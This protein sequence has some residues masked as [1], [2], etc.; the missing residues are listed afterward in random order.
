MSEF[1]N[2]IGIPWE[3]G[4][5]GPDSFDC[6]SFASR[7]LAEQFGRILPQVAVPVLADDGQHYIMPDGGVWKIVAT[8]QH[9]D[10]CMVAFPAAHCGVWLEID[11]GGVLHCLPGCGVIF[12]KNKDWRFGRRQYL[13]PVE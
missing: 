2:Y 9:G 4:A 11:G 8:P 13:R 5:N 6:A 12:T 3:Q 1:A 7:V 10:L